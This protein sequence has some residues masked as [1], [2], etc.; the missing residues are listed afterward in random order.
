M[1]AEIK[2]HFKKKETQ[3]NIKVPLTQE[4]R[5]II[6]KCIISLIEKLKV[7]NSKIILTTPYKKLPK[8]RKELKEIEVSIENNEESLDKLL[9]EIEEVHKEI[10]EWLDEEK[11]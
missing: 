9:S 10:E 11:F 8:E 4:E 7:D 5:E 1:K 3:I 6:N 2:V